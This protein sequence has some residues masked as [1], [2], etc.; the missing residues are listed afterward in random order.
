MANCV[1]TPMV[2]GRGGTSHCAHSVRFGKYLF[3][4]CFCPMRAATNTWHQPQLIKKWSQMLI[5]ECLRHQSDCRYIYIYIY[6]SDY[7]SD[8]I[9]LFVTYIIRRMATASRWISQIRHQ[10]ISTSGFSRQ[11][12]AHIRRGLIASLPAPYVP[13]MRPCLQST[14][15]SSVTDLDHGWRG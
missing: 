13:I 12:Q 3:L 9:S 7:G 15:R 8:G 11:C 14:V 2:A 1:L 5:V 4:V 10:P 6:I